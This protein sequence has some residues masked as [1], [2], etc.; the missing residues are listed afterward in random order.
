MKH[1]L[2]KLTDTKVKVT[3]ELTA[4]ELA[5]AK[6]ATLKEMAPHVKVA[7]FRKGKVPA[8]VAEKNIDPTQLASETAQNAINIA[9]NDIVNKEDIR[10]LDQPDVNLTDF[11]A[12]E[13]LTF[14]A[15][16]EVLPEI[17]LGDYTKL[18]AEKEKVSITAKDID[19]VIERIQKGFAE[20]VEV[21]RPAKNGDEAVI[22]F[23][24]SKDGKLVDGATGKEYPLVLGSNS[25]IPGFE[26][27][28]VGHKTGDVFDL[29]LTFPK[30]YHSAE[31]KGAKVT[32]KVT[33]VKVNEVK[34][35]KADDELAAKSGP[36]TSLADMKADIKKELTAQKEKSAS[37]NLKDALVGQ[38]VEKSTI[39][40]PEVLIE[41]QMKA[42]ERDFN[43]NLMYQGMSVEQFLEVQGYKDHD[44]L[45]EKEFRPAAERR[46]Q[47]GLVLAELSKEL[48]IEVSQ[49]ELEARLED[50]KTQSPSMAA[51]LDSPDARRDLANR[52][53]TEKT[54]DK[55][56]ELNSK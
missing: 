45:H 9:M 11:N 43:Q 38:L 13:A 27:G 5:T 23:E 41:D 8:D 6:K 51:Q 46:V 28:I 3:V 2:E 24:G 54:V 52:V 29:P 21:D 19:E 22:D 4:A 56:V 49:A 55:L 35:P 18:K 47:A 10:V 40:L 33:V 17:K 44:E 1:T 36:F 26:E 34:L 14:T 30:D 15:E 20:K 7:G 42:I 48:K 39:P 32:F 16:F 53:L 31:L 50:M 25:F 37:D 12:Y